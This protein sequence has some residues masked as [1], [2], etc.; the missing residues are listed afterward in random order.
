VKV[1]KEEITTLGEEVYLNLRKLV[2]WKLMALSEFI[3]E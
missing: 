3:P 2:K 1:Q